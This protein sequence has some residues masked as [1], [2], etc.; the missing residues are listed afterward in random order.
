MT[1][2]NPIGIKSKEGK[3]IVSYVIKSSKLI[4]IKNILEN[5]N[6]KLELQEKAKSRAKDFRLENMLENLYRV[7]QNL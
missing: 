4:T 1:L 5:E 2:L 6:L 7:Y 3:L